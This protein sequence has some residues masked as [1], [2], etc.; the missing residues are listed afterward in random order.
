MKTEKYKDRR[1]RRRIKNPQGLQ[2]KQTH[3]HKQI[4]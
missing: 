2:Q 4:K 1:Q 3:K